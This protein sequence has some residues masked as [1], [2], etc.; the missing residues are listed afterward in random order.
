MTVRLI[1]GIS[2]DR[3]LAWMMDVGKEAVW[4]DSLDGL[5]VH[6]D[7]RTGDLRKF[8]GIFQ[9][10]RS[11]GKITKAHAGEFGG[12]VS[13]HKTLDILRVKRIQHGIRAVKDA[14]LVSR[15]VDEGITLDLCPWSNVKLGAVESLAG[16]PLPEFHRSGIRVSVNTDDPTLFGRT[17]TDEYCWLG[18]EMGLSYRE[19]GAIASN[20]FKNAAMHDYIRDACRKEID[21]AVV[22]YEVNR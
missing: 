17:L 9:E 22:A 21:S 2:M 5:D 18:K 12:P 3:D 10:A 15:L 1:G 8:S 6:G 14:S 4:C 20:P 13:I 19:I 7:E 16:H 11:N